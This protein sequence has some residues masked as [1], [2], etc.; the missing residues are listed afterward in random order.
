ML[1]IEMVLKW[2]PEEEQNV[3]KIAGVE[4]FLLLPRGTG[5]VR[6]LLNEPRLERAIGVVYRPRTERS[7]H[8]FHAR[9]AEQFDALI[10]FDATSAVAPLEP[11][12][13]AE[14]AELPET[15]PTGV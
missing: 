6:T 11:W 8:Y 10:H 12:A 3:P 1:R 9:L 14:S 7:S 15:Y 4:R 2:A 5:E 13:V